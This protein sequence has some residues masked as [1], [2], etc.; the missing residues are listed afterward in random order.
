MI[1]NPLFFTNHLANGFPYCCLNHN[2]NVGVGIAFPAFAFQNPTRLSATRGISGAGYCLTEMAV[3]ELRI[4]LHGAVTIKALL[5]TQLHTAQV[6]YR[7][8][9]CCLHSL[10]TTRVGT[11]I[12]SSDNAQ[13]QVQTR[14][15]I[16]NL[17]ARD[18]RRTIIKTS[19]RCGAACA[20][21]DVFI[22]LAVLV[23]TWSKTLN[24][25]HDHAWVEMLNMLPGKTHAI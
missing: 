20:L 23:R 7:V 17:R 5:V 14:S 8:L 24:R 9:H 25:C 12:Q 3:R 19:G 18:H 16:T 4:L 1:G 2:I 10:T 6:Q 15:T 22:N 13:G 21:R 11:L